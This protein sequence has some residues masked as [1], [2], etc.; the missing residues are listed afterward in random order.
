[1]IILKTPGT[2]T[3]LGIVVK[4]RPLDIQIKKQIRN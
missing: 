4:K 2:F 3:T 1:M